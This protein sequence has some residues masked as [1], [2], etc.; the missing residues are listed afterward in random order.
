MLSNEEIAA[1]E[2]DIQSWLNIQMAF[3]TAN[4]TSKPI[5]VTEDKE[6]LYTTVLWFLVCS[7][8]YQYIPD[9][10]DMFVAALSEKHIIHIHKN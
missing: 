6:A 10:Y 9:K 1:I 8:V 4:T 5:G 3:W 2:A 7:Y